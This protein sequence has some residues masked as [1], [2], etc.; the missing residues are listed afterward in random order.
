MTYL[1]SVWFAGS[2]SLTGIVEN[3]IYDFNVQNGLPPTLYKAVAFDGKG[4]L[5]VGTLDDG[6][7]KS[8]VPVNVEDLNEGINHKIGFT[9]FWTREKGAPTN[10]IEKLLWLQDKMWVGTQE[11]LLAVDS[12]T[13]EIVNRLSRAEG[14]PA[15]N[16]ISF[17]AS[18]ATGNIWIGTNQG[19]AEVDP[20]DT[21]VLKTLSRQDGLIDNEVWLYGSVQVDSEGLVYFGTANGLSVYHPKLDRLNEFSPS[22]QLT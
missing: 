9:Q 11:G 2:R 20:V 1:E 22:L 8:N 21:R 15:D 13:G 12:D 10:H 19:L 5:W 7:Y 4:H 18:P 6:I 14:L 3:E 17:A 16:T